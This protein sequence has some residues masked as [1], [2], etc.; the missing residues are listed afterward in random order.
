MQLSVPTTVVSQ[1]PDPAAREKQSRES[2][3]E[4]SIQFAAPAE[5]TEQFSVEQASSLPE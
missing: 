4:W 1:S 5:A 3:S 2:A